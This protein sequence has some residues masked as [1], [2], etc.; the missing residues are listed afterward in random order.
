MEKLNKLRAD[1]ISVVDLDAV[2]ESPRM[3]LVD[4]PVYTLSTVGKTC[5]NSGRLEAE[6]RYCDNTGEF[7][8]RVGYEPTNRELGAI[9]LDFRTLGAKHLSTEARAPAL[10]G[11]KDE[12][13]HYATRAHDYKREIA[14][15]AV[16][17][18]DAVAKA[19]S[20][21][22]PA[23]S[24]P[25]S[26]IASIQEA[27]IPASGYLA[28]SY[29]SSESGDDLDMDAWGVPLEIEGIPEDSS[30]E[31]PD[32]EK[33]FEEVLANWVRYAHAID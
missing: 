28:Y 33:E 10:D 25:C 23:G 1:A 12:H 9:L 30:E 13:V 27:G 29:T 7:V 20:A 6:R 3:P 32:F 4:A 8:S 19:E 21:G 22:K 17:H 2:L 14:A 15:A 24:G 5:L 26:A 16:A 18:A 11:L 31:V